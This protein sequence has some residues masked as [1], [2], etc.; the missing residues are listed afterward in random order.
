MIVSITDY[1][2]TDDRNFVEYSV[3]D[4]TLNQ[5]EFLNDNLDEET[6]IDGNLFKLKMYFEDRLYPFQSDVAQFRMNDFIAR[7]EI[8]MNMFLSSFLEDM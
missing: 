3:S 8:E 2:K 7:E 1:G 5:M 4:L 6:E